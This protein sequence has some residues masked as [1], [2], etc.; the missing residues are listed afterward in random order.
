MR[1]FLADLSI[2]RVIVGVALHIG[3]AAENVLEHLLID[4]PAGELRQALR[5]ILA[6]G[7]VRRWT[8]GDAD[9]P[10]RVRQQAGGCK[11]IER[12]HQQPMRQVSRGAENNEATGI[13]G[14]RRRSARPRCH[15][16]LA[17]RS[18]GSTCAPKPLR[19]AVRIFSAK[20]WSRR[21]RKRV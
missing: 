18:L 3:D 14:S 4:R 5:E 13:G 20:G 9:Q 10:E 1:E 11:I 2:C 16:G 17:L 19:M 6:K 12:R 8:A 7:L 21:E 15:D